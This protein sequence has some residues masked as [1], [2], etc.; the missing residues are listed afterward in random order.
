MEAIAKKYGLELDADW[1][2]QLLPHQGRHPNAYHQ[3]VLD[4][5]RLADNEAA[6]DSS[7]FLELY[8]EL[9]KKPVKENPEMVRKSW[10]C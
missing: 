10:W 8:E 4:N 3:F 7:R 5:M 1:N 2:L 9:V 6:G